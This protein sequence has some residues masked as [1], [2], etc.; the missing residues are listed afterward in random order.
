MS[1]ITWPTSGRA[2][3]AAQFSEALAF[4]VEITVARAG[5][6][7]TRMLPG[8]RWRASIA[9]PPETKANRVYRQQLEAFIAKLRG[10]A[11]W[12]AM[13]NPAKPTPLGTLTGS[14]LVKVAAGI[15]DTAVS[16]KACNGGLLRGDL[17][18]M[19]GQ[20][21]MVVA[22]VTPVASEMTVTVEPPLRAAIGVDTP[23]IWDRPLSNFVMT[24]PEV[25]F[26]YDGSGYPGFGIELIEA[27]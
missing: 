23:V 2:H 20:R 7:T 11:N 26:P 19:A 27:W 3:D 25:F 8:W 14:P 1:I 6:V 17:I 9:M 18:S 12:L 13:F 15:G 16:L 5:N 21:V 22:D 10:G 4:D 24:S